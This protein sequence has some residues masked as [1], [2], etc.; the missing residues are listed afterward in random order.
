MIRSW[1]KATTMSPKIFHQT[2]ELPTTIKSENELA[3][4]RYDA[5]GHNDVVHYATSNNGENSE[6]YTELI[7]I[8]CGLIMFLLL[9]M[10]GKRIWSCIQRR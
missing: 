3:M 4:V 1:F 9:S 2:T 10:I 6:D 5:N 7:A 8:F